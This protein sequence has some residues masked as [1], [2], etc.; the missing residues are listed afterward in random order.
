M[1][2]PAGQGEDFFELVAVPQIVK[3]WRG[4]A[5]LGEARLG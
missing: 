3:V 5:R 2:G 4:E 1:L